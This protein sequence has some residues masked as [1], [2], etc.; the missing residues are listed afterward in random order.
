MRRTATLLGPWRVTIATATLTF[1][2]DRTDEAWSFKLDQQ[3]GQAQRHGQ[4]GASSLPRLS[5]SFVLAHVTQT[6]PMDAWTSM[7]SLGIALQLLEF[8]L[9]CR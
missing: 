6:M 2:S 7:A 1:V 5:R 3:H 9:F 4:S 8:M